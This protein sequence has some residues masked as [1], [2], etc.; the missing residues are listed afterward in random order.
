MYKVI[1][2]LLLL[3]SFTANA[4]ESI[5]KDYVIKP[6]D[7]LSKL[8]IKFLGD[9][10]RWPE[11]QR[12]N[13]VRGTTIHVGD[14][15][16]ICTEYE[17]IDWEYS[18]AKILLTRMEQLLPDKQAIETIQ[19]LGPSVIDGI[20]KAATR[21][22]YR[23]DVEL[24][25]YD[26]LELC[27]EAITTIEH[28]SFYQYAVGTV[29]ELG[30]YQFRVTTAQETLEKYEEREI[31]IRDVVIALANDLE[32]TYVFALHFYQ[33]KRRYRSRWTAWKRY[34]GYGEHAETYAERIMKKYREIK[35]LGI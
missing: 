30:L 16:E 23:Y 29:G 8:A 1:T 5:C 13:E 17:G 2:I 22:E 33:L 27:R 28:E 3:F 9:M 15:L 7:T 18:C 6:G 12:H 10:K 34:N 25:P 19:D 26:R 4:Q 14:T 32:S 24:D 20:N 21:I 11:I 35:A 31:P